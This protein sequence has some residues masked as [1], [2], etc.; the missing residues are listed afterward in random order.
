MSTFK[1]ISKDPPFGKSLRVF[2]IPYQF[3]DQLYNEGKFEIPKEMPKVY[4]NQPLVLKSGEKQ[5]AL[6]YVCQYG[7]YVIKARDDI[8]FFGVKGRNKEQVLLQ[9]ALEN[10]NIRCIV[11][12]GAA[13]T[14]KT[15]ILSSYA[16]EQIMGGKGAKGS[17]KEE[18]AYEK[19]ILSK[20]LEVVGGRS[21]YFGT[22]PG[23]VD[24]KF[25][26]FLR[27]FTMTFENLVGKNGSHY[28]DR[29]LQKGIIEFLPLELMRGASLQKSVVYYDEAQNLSQFDVLTLGTRL[30]DVGLSKLFL[31]G[32]LA[33][34]DR[35]MAKEKTGLWKLMTSPHFLKSDLTYHIHLLKIER[36]RLAEL[37][38]NVFDEDD[39]S[40]K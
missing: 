15:L 6:A 26:P 28:I 10:P 30:D 37:F 33:Q 40:K 20:P 29:M 22:V 9:N 32:D 14:G 38:H 31:S 5:S 17:K 23:D 2:E 18:N 16:L 13:G 35:D 27:S 39:S 11:V 7:K 36:G 34:R 8:E 21:K 24:A 1:D 12:T 3:I 19:L 4:P 25:A